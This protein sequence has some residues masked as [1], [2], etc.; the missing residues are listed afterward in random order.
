MI[1]RKK[2]GAAVHA[3]RPASPAQLAFRGELKALQDAYTQA[4][5]TYQKAKANCKHTIEY[6]YTPAKFGDTMY[7]DGSTW[8]AD[9]GVHF[10]HFCPESPDNACH[11]YTEDGLHVRLVTGELVQKPHDPPHPDWDFVTVEQDCR[12]FETDDVCL[13][14]KH[15][16]ERK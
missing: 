3:I 11:Y 14:C 13:F 9:C 4:K 6:S 7:Y 15:P 8:C 2:K 10:G 12:Q 16:H 5:E 1:P